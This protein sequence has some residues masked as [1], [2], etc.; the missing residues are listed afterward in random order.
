MAPRAALPENS[1]PLLG[2]GTPPPHGTRGPP[3]DSSSLPLRRH[4]PRGE[5]VVPGNA[6]YAPD[7]LQTWSVPPL[8]GHAED[9]DLC[10]GELGGVV[11]QSEARGGVTGHTSEHGGAVRED[12]LDR[13]AVGLGELDG[14]V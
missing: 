9:E 13:G 12:R 11:V 1:P 4:Q 14:V 8:A 5:V 3:L 2:S 10:H 7:K 6:A